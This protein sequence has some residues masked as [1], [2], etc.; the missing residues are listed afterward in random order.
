MFARGY[1][2]IEDFNDDNTNSDDDE[3]NVDNMFARGDDG[4]EDNNDDNSNSEDD[5]GN[6]DNMFARGSTCDAF[7]CNHNK[8]HHCPSN[9]P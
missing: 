5:E 3:G 6:V 7:S 4:I 1:A 8:S 9:L 2:G